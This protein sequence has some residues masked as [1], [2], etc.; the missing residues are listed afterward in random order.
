MCLTSILR[1]ALLSFCF[2]IYFYLVCL[3]VCLSVCMYVCMYDCKYAC[4]PP[5]FSTSGSQKRTLDFLGAGVA[6]VSCHVGGGN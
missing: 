5:V 3:S 1:S 4:V 6:V 2:K